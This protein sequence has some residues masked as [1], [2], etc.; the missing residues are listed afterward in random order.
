MASKSENLNRFLRKG[1]TLIVPIDHGNAIPVPGL[2]SPAKVIESLNRYADGYVVNYGVASRYQRALGGKGVCL[3]TDVYKPAEKGQPDDGSFRIYDATDAGKLG[4][5]AMMN[6]AYPNHPNERGMLED[7]TTLVRSGRAE[8]IPLIVET[9]PYGLG[10]T[11]YYT[12]ENIGF[13][14]RQAAELGADVVKTAFP[15]GASVEDFAK[16]V[17]ACFVPVIILGGAAMGDDKALLKMVADAME[18]GAIG[19]A[20]GRNIWQHENPTGIAR[21]MAAVIHEGET[22]AEALKLVSAPPESDDHENE[23]E[24]EKEEAPDELAPSSD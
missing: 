13:A 24:I 3:R 20:I 11:K 15:T 10:Q 4:A 5:N 17:E 23:V 19:V 18:A 12:A 9:L 8:G 21:A 1:R 7:C 2:E 22:V 6:M 16:V 14:A